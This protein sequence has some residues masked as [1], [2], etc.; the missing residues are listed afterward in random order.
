LLPSVFM[1]GERIVV[2][3]SSSKV[4]ASDKITSSLTNLLHPSLCEED[5]WSVITECG[6]Y[7]DHQ[8]WWGWGDVDNPSVEQNKH[9]PCGRLGLS[10]LP[11]PSPLSGI[12][13]QKSEP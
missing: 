3:W 9:A 6:F 11:M 12:I 8:W 5:R 2:C 13:L 7:F 4:M 1:D 10:G